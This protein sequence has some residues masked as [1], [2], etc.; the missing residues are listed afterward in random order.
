MNIFVSILVW[1]IPILLAITSHEAAHAWVAD[2]LGDHTAKRLGRLSFNPLRHIDLVGTVILPIAILILTNFQFVFGFAKPVPINSRN[3]SRPMR[4]E[5]LVAAAGP[6]TNF[7]MAIAWTLFYKLIQ[8]LVAVNSPFYEIFTVLAQA[9][10]L[11]NLL[12]SFINL[13][14]IPPLDGS[15]ILASTL[16]TKYAIKYLKIEPYGYIILIVLLLSGLLNQ[17]FDIVFI[18]VAKFI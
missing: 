10:V 8:M 15:R 3:F 4:D 18:W 14:P 11:T 17:L 9:G 6:L 2:L 1:I 5:A 13:I 12:L 16:P 7:L